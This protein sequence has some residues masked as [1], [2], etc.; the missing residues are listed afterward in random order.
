[1]AEHETAVD[2]H[3]LVPRCVVVHGGT[4]RGGRFRKVVW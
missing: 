1:M 2:S 3:E 4:D